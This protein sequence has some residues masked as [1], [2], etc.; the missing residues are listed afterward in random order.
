MAEQWFYRLLG[1]EFGPVST[2]LL[3]QLLQDGTLS[4]TDEVRRAGSFTWQPARQALTGAPSPAAP[5]PSAPEPEPEWYCQIAGIEMGPLLLDDL[6]RMAEN[7][8]LT[9]EDD[10]RYGAQGKWRKAL[11]VGRLASV[12]DLS[13]VRQLRPG[14]AVTPPQSFAVTPA[15]TSA[16]V[17]RR[18]D[19]PHVSASA[20]V[21]AAARSTPASGMPVTTLPPTPPVA[22]RTV[23]PPSS[24][25]AVAHAA[26]SSPR[27]EV[28]TPPAETRAV[29]SEGTLVSSPAP[30]QVS[31]RAAAASTTD[32]QHTASSA[33][34]PERPTAAAVS[35]PTSAPKP[36]PAW[37][38][39]SARPPF[40]PPKRSSSGSSVDWGALWQPLLQPKVLGSLAVI[41]LAV[42][43][44]FGSSLLPKSTAGDRKKLETLQKLHA[45]FRSLRDKKASPAE[46]TAFTQKADKEVAAIVAELN[47]TASRREPW[48]QQ[49]LW[50]AKYRWKE[51]MSTG[52]EKPIAAEKDFERNLYEAARQLGVEQ[53]APAPKNDG[54][55]PEDPDEED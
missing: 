46:W 51:M 44:V 13:K 15:P 33:A 40:T 39:P 30:Q 28:A 31:P 52:R 5:A 49:L 14:M 25:P 4:P 47:R 22:G 55:V 2:E 26:S 7:G 11:T 45:E 9:A 20:T 3:Q 48:K 6:V 36:T 27:S 24:A 41:L 1:E 23:S 17:T 18:A 37:T 53:T 8:E 34:A 10:V 29:R 43:A 12:M 35:A 50:A 32:N 19:P 42:V 38:P 54:P 21:A 16:A